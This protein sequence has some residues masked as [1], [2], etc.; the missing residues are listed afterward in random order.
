MLDN[1]TGC[2]Q[3]TRVQTF[4]VNF[5]VMYLLACVG[6]QCRL[7]GGGATA[8]PRLPFKFVRPSHNWWLGPG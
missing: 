5:V 4:S 3:M 6:P 1:K 7:E 2:S 8:P